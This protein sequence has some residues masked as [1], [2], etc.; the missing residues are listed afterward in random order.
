MSFSVDVRKFC[1]KEAPEKTDKIIR[2]IVME[3]GNRIVMRSP[4]GDASYWQMP[5]PP[6]YTGGRFRGNWQYGHGLVPQ[7]DVEV[8]DKSGSQTISAI[9]RGA[10]TSKA[11]GVHWI[12]NNAP[13]SERLES[14]WSRQA[15]MGMVGLTELEFPQIVEMA[16][17]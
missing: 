7:G 12:V 9:N 2:E 6:G 17:R 10:M 5:P 16:R 3:I 15:P 4:V 8:I 13:Y 1:E 11:M 14:G